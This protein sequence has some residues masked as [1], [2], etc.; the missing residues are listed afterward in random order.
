MDRLAYGLAALVGIAATALGGYG[1]IGGVGTLRLAWLVPLNGL[2]LTLDP[3]GG[4]FLALIGFAAVP[5]SI[6][7]MGSSPGERRDRF[8]YLVFVLSMCLVPL[9]ANTMTFAITW[10]LMSLA[11]YFLVLH[12]RESKAS[13]YAGWVYA[14]MTHAGLACLLAGMLLLGAWTGS[15]RFE[16]WRAA[17]P[18]L[19]G[20]ARNAVFVLLGLGF[21]GKAGVIPLHV[22]LPLAHPAAP[23]HVSALMSAVMIKLGVYGLLRVSLDWLGAGPAWWGVAILVAGAASSVIGVLY[24][25]VD[26]DLKRLLA[27][28]S[29]E[30]IGI[31]LLGVGSAVLYHGAGLPAP[32]LLGLAAALYHTVNHA[33]FKALLFLGAGAVVHATGTRNMEELGGLIKRMPWTAACFLVGSAAIAALPPLNGFVSEWLTFVALFQNRHLAAVGL[34]LVFIL[35]IASLALTGGLAMACFVKA[36]GI[37]FLALPR[38]EAA[39]RAHEAPATMRLAMLTLAAACVALGLGPTLVIPVLGAVAAS[40]LEQAPPATVGDWLT[41]Q[42]SGGYASLSTLAIAIALG[43]ALLVPLVALPLVRA[44]RRTRDYETWGCGRIVQTARMEY[45]ATAFAN[46]FKRVF[47]FFYRPTRHLDIEFHP[48]SRFFV[49]RIE[50]ENP[51]RSIFDDWLYRPAL[52]LLRAGAR[53]AG[54]LQSGSANLYLAYILAALLM[55][56][57]LA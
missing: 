20:A 53:A 24:A 8:A 28:H 13:I 26:H 7:A 9:A 48:E 31:I 54:A 15:P 27:F 29:I 49:R 46:P 2:E 32:A 38:S 1:M 35:G 11:S 5:A 25:L 44:S 56:L 45:T 37:T 36:F 34:N 50:Y 57:V 33:A 47:D 22:W 40:L 6:Y 16:D 51:A 4:F 19:S 14:V 12:N 17:A 39:A 23:S 52:D 10:E 3:L 55:M 42:V 41:L 43:A 18:A 21:A 30:N